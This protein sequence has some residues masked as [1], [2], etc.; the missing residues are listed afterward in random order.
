M[1]TALAGAS[2]DGAGKAAEPDIDATALETAAEAI[3]TE[4]TIGPADELIAAGID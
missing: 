2:A 3:E 4:L 1:G